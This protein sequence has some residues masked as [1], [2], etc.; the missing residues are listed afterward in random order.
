[1]GYGVDSRVPEEYMTIDNLNYFRR[2]LI[3]EIDIE[4]MSNNTIQQVRVV[5]NIIG[6]RRHDGD[7]EITRGEVVNVNEISIKKKNPNC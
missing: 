1:M 2:L 5:Y 6:I 4:R 3:T 7:D